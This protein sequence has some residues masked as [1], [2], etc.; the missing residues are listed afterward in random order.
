M[1]IYL[2]NFL[3][4][5]WEN[6]KL[7]S[8]LLLNSP[9]EDVKNNLAEFFTNNFYEN[10]LSSKCI[11]NNLLYLITLLLKEEIN[12]I[13]NKEQLDDFLND[14]HCGYILKQLKEKKE[15][16]LFFKTIIFDVLEKCKELDL[17]VIKDFT[18]NI[19]KIEEK[20]IK[21]KENHNNYKENKIKN[22]N[23]KKN[24][25]NIFQTKYIKSL[26]EE[27]LKQYLSNYKK[28]TNK[29]NINNYI[30]KINNT[31][32]KTPFL[33]ETKVF[34]NNV[35]N[36]EDILNLY[37]DYFFKI[38][39][40][41]DI[42][43]NNLLNNIYLLPYQ[44]KCICK[45]ISKFIK[46]KFSDIDIVENNA[47]I[48]KFFFYNLFFP[49]LLN[50]CYSSLLNDFILSKNENNILLII[51]EILKKLVSGKL[52]QNNKIEGNLTP[53][54]WL[55][56]E[57]MPKIIEIY[58]KITN[59]KLPI[60][61]EKL[62]NHE[63]NDDYKY[64]YLEENKDDI[65]FHNSICFTIDDLYVLIKNIN[66]SK[67]KILKEN[68]NNE[69]EILI[70]KILNEDNLKRFEDLYFRKKKDWEIVNDNDNDINYAKTF[71]LIKPSEKN[72]NTILNYINKNKGK[73]KIQ[74]FLITY[75]K[76]NSEYDK[77][78]NIK[79]KKSYYNIVNEKEG[80]EGTIIIDENKKII[81]TIKNFII[82]ILYNFNT[83]NEEDFSEESRINTINILTEIGKKM[84]ALNILIDG[85]IQS[86][87][88]I[89]TLLEYLEK[90]PKELTN[91][92][93]EK[94]YQ[95]LKND[96]K[97][98]IKN[99]N[100]DKVCVFMDKV[101][102]A[103][104]LK[105]Y[106]ENAFKK[107][108]DIDLDSET[109]RIIKKTLIPVRIKHKKNKNYLSIKPIENNIDSNNIKNKNKNKNPKTNEN[110]I[111]EKNCETIED[112]INNF[113]D[114]NKEANN[115]KISV[116]VT[117]KD[118][119][120]AE[121]MNKYVQTIEKTISEGKKPKNE[122]ELNYIIN[123]IYDYIMEKLYNK[124]YP[125]EIEPTDNMVYLSCNKA[126][127]IEPKHL[128]TGKKDFI[129]SPFISDV[130]NYFE[131]IDKQKCPKKKFF[132]MEE[133]FKSIYNLNAFI[134]EELGGI[135]EEI[136]ILNY[137]LIK[138]KPKKIYSNCEYMRLFL[139]NK[140]G[141]REDIHLT[142][143]TVLSEQV[144][145]LNS[146]NLINITESEYNDKCKKNITKLF[147]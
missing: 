63:L 25:R 92:D 54:N 34:T 45:I 23:E 21:N 7:I 97:E 35:N 75:Y 42:I 72:E 103:E 95:E 29:D 122:Y 3:E 27:D 6:P 55:I 69:L 81:N 44:I 117:L 132:Y 104:T 100:F 58:T 140:K 31:I 102:L 14:T 40:F 124:I 70:K 144:A 78:F 51:S 118:I 85:T 61:I 20:I 94:I 66:K 99:I 16:K 53:F 136:Q 88:Y 123:K 120:F 62:I 107:L 112:F 73:E 26:N 96:L 146:S 65:L 141:K 84:K 114:L 135:D 39:E 138:A 130:S 9:I 52:F 89:N 91:N 28:Q 38:S 74:H 47:F 67:D 147:N 133:I 108:I 121:K 87:W 18:L 143:I 129:Y 12:I 43:L 48:G 59:V 82:S 83:L 127:W 30:N 37:I 137:A 134:G 15:V 46:K 50:P 76:Y 111:M 49:M 19:K 125:S 93:Y 128:I 113:P 5:L 80:K 4:L 139:G 1:N 10:I 105:L 106:Y 145:K 101:K 33:Y 79:N 2:P 90:L 116:L 8:I 131:N 119:N 22:I 24:Q 109:N 17:S 126:S 32:N 142:Q 56:I 13:L 98:S 77:Y 71:N 11:E 68:D 110:I 60:F 115:R 86:K 64:N 36:N 41:I 57:K